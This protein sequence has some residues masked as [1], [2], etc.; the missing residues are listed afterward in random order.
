VLVIEARKV[1]HRRCSLVVTIDFHAHLAPHE[2]KAPPFL[3]LLF[4]VE[5]YLERQ[6][7][8]GIERTVL[9]YG[10]SDI[11]G[12]D[13]ELEEAKKQHDFLA[14]LVSRHPDRLSALAGIDPVGGDVWVAE[15]ERALDAG[16][17]GLCLPTSSG[18][19]YLD[20]AEAR[21]ILAFADERR[22]VVFLHPS[23]TPFGIDRVGDP[24][25]GNWIGRPCDTGICLSRMLLADTLS[26]FPNIS[27]VVAH[28]GGVLPMLLGRLDWV[29][30][31]FQRRAKLTAGGGPPGG[32]GP[33]PGHGPPQDVPE[34][35]KLTPALEGRKPSERID[36][37]HLDTA[38][39]HPAAVRA[40]I[41][42]VGI[43]RIVVG[44]DHPPVGDD[45]GSALAV[46]DEVGL[47]EEDREKVK[48]GN[49]RRLLG[50]GAAA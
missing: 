29:Y 2:P 41:E 12:G 49:A 40:A 6:E 26:E 11:R 50:V 18:G 24:T 47:S 1:Y 34:G 16:L 43:D 25:L 8:A 3:R 36:Q 17:A 22:I 46:L 13:E 48:S 19:R 23:D 20:T 44:T 28:G 5:G 10:I 35:E 7:S 30:E 14:D 38:T 4:D 21:D 45:P 15:A 31:G 33:P 39:Y 37:L 32:G 42:T 9:S 27:M